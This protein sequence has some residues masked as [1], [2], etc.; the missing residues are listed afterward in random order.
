MR[1]SMVS[2]SQMKIS[3]MHCHHVG[4]TIFPD[5]TDRWRD[6]RRSPCSRDGEDLDLAAGSF[7]NDSSVAKDVE[8][9]RDFQGVKRSAAGVGERRERSGREGYRDALVLRG[10]GTVAVFRRAPSQTAICSTA[11]FFN[12][13]TPCADSDSCAFTR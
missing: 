5:T 13:M 1:G 11:S 12:M 6:A 4:S 2:E 7:A 10:G 3:P 9:S 8:R